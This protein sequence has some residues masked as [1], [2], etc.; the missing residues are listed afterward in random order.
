[1]GKRKALVGIGRNGMRLG[2]IV[3]GGFPEGVNAFC[4]VQQR[5]REM[6]TP[7]EGR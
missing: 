1:M 7:E 5:C 2:V 3:N 4:D 6:P